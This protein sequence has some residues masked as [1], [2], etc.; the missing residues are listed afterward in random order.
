MS[1]KTMPY[2]KM[3]PPPR[4]PQRGWLGMGVGGAG[5]APYQMH[6][7]PALAYAAEMRAQTIG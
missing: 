2:L 4:K 7:D 6:G 1:K 3:P 5:Q